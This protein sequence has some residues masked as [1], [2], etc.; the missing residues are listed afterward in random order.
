MCSRI[1]VRSFGRSAFSSTL[2]KD[3]DVQ[4]IKDWVQV[5]CPHLTAQMSKCLI[6][7]I[8][9]TSYAA[10]ELEA[11]LRRTFP[12]ITVCVVN[13]NFKFGPRV[14]RRRD[15]SGNEVRNSSKFVTGGALQHARFRFLQRP[16]AFS[17]SLMISTNCRFCR[18]R[19]GRP[20]GGGGNV[21]AGRRLS[22]DSRCDW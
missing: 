2:S 4:W 11:E 12:G 3:T 14:W 9:S 22:S 7:T 16:K 20:S 1:S 6:M 17:T 5:L 13:W 21:A 15:A 18:V 19:M 8:T 10:R